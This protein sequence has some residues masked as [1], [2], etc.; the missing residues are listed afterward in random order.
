[1]SS[2]YNIEEQYLATLMEI[3]EEGE[4]TEN[5]TGVD[6]L[7]IDGVMLKHDMSL[8]F[9]LMTT[10]KMKFSNIASELEFFIKGKTSKKWLQDR[11]N[12]IW[13]H[14]CAPYKV[15][16]A[17]DEE[18]KAKMAAEDD[19]GPIYGAQWRAFQ[20]PWATIRDI[21]MNSNGETV[22]AGGTHVGRVVDQLKNCVDRLKAHPD[23][24][25]NIVSAWNPLALDRMAL[26]PCHV[27]FRVGVRNGKLNL[28]WYQRSCDF[29]L[30]V[31]YNIASYALLLHLLAK[32]TGYKEGQLTGFFDDAH[33]YINH[34][35]QVGKQLDRDPRKLPSIA[36]GGVSKPYSV[37]NWEYSDT[38]VYGYNPYPFIGAPVAV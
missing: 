35:D 18:T 1:M 21:K 25:R 11:G 33:L 10:K 32:E 27:L 24:R 4:R 3:M 23:C 30:G 2:R 37:F 16:Y 14:W 8:G 36:T 20:D 9:P 29:F 38:S 26:V 28:S 15:P 34:I 31:P 19:L 13:N 5:R 17:N 6:T 7:A 12:P 22:K